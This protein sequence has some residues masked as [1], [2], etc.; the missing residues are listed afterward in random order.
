MVGYAISSKLF[1][2]INPLGYSYKCHKQP[3]SSYQNNT[4]RHKSTKTLMSPRYFNVTS[5]IRGYD[6]MICITQSQIHLFNQYIDPQRVPQNFYRRITT[7]TCANPYA[8]VHG[9]NPQVDHQNIHQVDQQN[10][11]LLPWVSH[12]RHTSSVLKSLKTQSDKITPK[13]KLNPLQESRGG[14]N[15]IRSNYNSKARDTSRSYHLKNTRERDQT[16]S[17]WYIPSAPREN[18]W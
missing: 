8:Q 13:G 12:T 2:P 17:Y 16:H 1:F 14:R 7:K 4:L 5:S 3:Q 15:I 10:T 18:C 9:R 11:S 6:Y